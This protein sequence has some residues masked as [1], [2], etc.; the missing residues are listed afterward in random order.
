MLKRS[1]TRLRGEIGGAK[2]EL[3]GEIAAAKDELRG[4]IHGAKIELRGEI[5]TA[6]RESENRLLLTMAQL[7][8]DIADDTRH[9]VKVLMEQF[10]MQVGAVDDKYRDLPDR[11]TALEK[12]TGLE[13]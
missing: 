4:E 12:H 7:R 8:L 6:I 10:G 5:T 2:D 3:R 13:R 9:T 1:E 11:V